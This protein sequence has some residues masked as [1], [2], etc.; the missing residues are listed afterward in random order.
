MT[1]SGMKSSASR[2]R[3]LVGL[4]LF[5]TVFFL[6][7]HFHSLT[8]TAQ[9][10]KECGCL[11]GSRTQA[12]LTIAHSN[13]LPVLIWQPVRTES[14]EFF[15]LRFGTRWHSRAPPFTVSL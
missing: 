3:R 4:L 10:A 8:V 6:P 2:R 9:V 5:L 13:P 7:L 1:A 15:G 14:Q 12:G 11:Y